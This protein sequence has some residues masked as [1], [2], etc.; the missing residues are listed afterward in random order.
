MHILI[1]AATG[2]E[3]EIT[4]HYL[5][6]KGFNINRHT[7]KL[8]TTGVGTMASAY[9]L[10][11][12][13]VRKKPD[14]VLQAGIA[15]SFHKSLEPEQV[16][17]VREELQGDLGVFEGGQFNDVFDMQLADANEFPFSQKKLINPYCKDW[18]RYQL[19]FVRG[20]TVNN[21][22]TGEK[23]IQLLIDKYHPEIESMEGAALHYTCL[24]ENIPF[25]QVRAISNYVGER[26]KSKWKMKEAIRNLNDSIIKIIEELP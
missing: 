20:L 3:I 16:V 2:L 23:N 15:G 18:E 25:M 26:D 21:I 17:L 7:T 6:S 4:G 5:A 19:P 11:K 13:V 24:L 12:E 14:Y 1:V 22:T 8:L 10:T 9:M